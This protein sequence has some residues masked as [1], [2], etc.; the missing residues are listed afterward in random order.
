MT[1]MQ[2]LFVCTGNTCRSAMAEAAA[3]KLIADAPEQYRDFTIA[4]AGVM[5]AGPSPASRYAVLAAQQNGSDLSLHTAKQVTDTMLDAADY[6]F[7][8]TQGHKQML[9]RMAPQYRDKIFLLNAYAYGTPDTADIPDPYGG[10][11]EEY[12][13]CYAELEKSVTQILDKL[14]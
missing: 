1:T 6:V 11:L 10:S 14:K 2:L 12:L 7:A 9:E 8:M 4:S 5:C 3:R 13:Q